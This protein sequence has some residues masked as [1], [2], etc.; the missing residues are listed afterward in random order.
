METTE[1]LNNKHRAQK[2]LWGQSTNT[3]QNKAMSTDQI[4]LWLQVRLTWLRYDGSAMS[5][6]A[7]FRSFSVIGQKGDPLT[8]DR[9]CRAPR[10][11]LRTS[12]T[13]EERQPSKDG[14]TETERR[15][16]SLMQKLTPV[17]AC[18]R[19]QIYANMLLQ[20]D[21]VLVSHQVSCQLPVPRE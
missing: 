6:S 2:Q 12:R 21:R 17:S 8:P 18:C 4:M 15:D 7:V 1:S 14:T 19:S 3:S 10:A 11:A 9:L 16:D 5:S 20:D 13:G